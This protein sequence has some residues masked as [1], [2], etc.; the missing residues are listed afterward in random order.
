[1]GGFLGNNKYI[2]AAFTWFFLLTSCEPG[3]VKEENEKLFT[4]VAADNSGVNF[5][6]NLDENEKFN[7]LNY[8]YFFNGGG[9]ASAESCASSCGSCSAQRHHRNVLSAQQ[10]RR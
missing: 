3:L 1:M 6:N 4:K 10:Q 9:V 5:Y 2:L 7:I 8:L